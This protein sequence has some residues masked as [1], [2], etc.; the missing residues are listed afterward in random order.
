MTRYKSITVNENTFNAVAEK[1][2]TLYQKTKLSKAQVVEAL[3]N[4]SCIEP[5]NK[6]EDHE[7]E[8]R[9]SEDT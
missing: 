2:T 3:V 5:N 1:Q 6:K 9:Q 8:K 7:T 4:V